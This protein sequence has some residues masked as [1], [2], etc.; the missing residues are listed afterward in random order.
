MIRLVV[1]LPSEAKPLISYYKLKAVEEARAFKVYRGSQ[2][3]LIVSGLGKTAAAAATAYLQATTGNGSNHAWINIGMAGHP[4]M[5]LGESILAQRIMDL[6]S[7]ESWYPPPV[8]HV[9]SRLAPVLTVD[10]VERDFEA[11]WVYEMEAAGFYP[12]AC[13]F[14]TSEL[15]HS[16]KV[17]S[18]NR[19]VPPRWLSTHQVG[20]LI[21]AKLEEIAQVVEGTAALARELDFIEADPPGFEAFTKRWHFTVSE[22]RRLHRLLR[23]W[24]VLEPEAEIMGEELR[25]RRTSREAL[26]FVQQRIESLPTR[27]PQGS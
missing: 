3:A 8:L 22:K 27:I 15:V 19:S 5:A 26:R 16:F 13:R 9:P 17:I 18:D 11:E 14:S 21:E 6:A 23:R 24:N 7:G 25:M 12:T 1:A 10:K 4:D 20:E 2:Y